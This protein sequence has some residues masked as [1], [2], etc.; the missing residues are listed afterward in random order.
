MTNTP[1][2]AS[3]PQKPAST[4][5]TPGQNGQ[6]NQGDNKPAADKPGQAPQK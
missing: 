1:I 5:V 2:S 3:E 6:P 4:P